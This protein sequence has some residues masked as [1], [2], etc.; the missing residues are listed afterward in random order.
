MT[1][2]LLTVSEVAA[3]AQVSERTV[4]RAIA[5]GELAAGRAGAQLRVAPDDA[6]AW[7]FGERNDVVVAFPIDDGVTLDCTTTP[8]EARSDR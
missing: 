3:W 5:D 4:R 1:E 2:R 6:H 8:K 7:V